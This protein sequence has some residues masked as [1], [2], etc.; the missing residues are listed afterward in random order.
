M[1]VP[2]DYIWA[3]FYL[4]LIFLAYYSRSINR[5]KSAAKLAMLLVF[6]FMAFRAP[7]VGGDTWNYVRYLTGE[8]YYY[9]EDVRD[10]ETF[11]LFYSYKSNN[12]EIQLKHINEKRK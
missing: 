1:N 4:C 11:F 5:K 9:N 7:V 6:I 2:F 10:L 8:R 3:I 12:Y